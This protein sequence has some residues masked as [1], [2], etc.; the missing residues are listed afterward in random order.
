MVIINNNTKFSIQHTKVIRK[1]ISKSRFSASFPF[2]FSPAFSTEGGASAGRGHLDTPYSP[3]RPLPPPTAAHPL[4][5]LPRIPPAV[6]ADIH[7]SIIIT[8]KVNA[9]VWVTFVNGRCRQDIYK[10]K[11][12]GFWIDVN[13]SDCTINT[14]LR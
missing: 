13:G 12:S 8:G 3:T 7:K 1:I 14:Q 9:G 10:T 5:L 4:N 11:V 6:A 2:S